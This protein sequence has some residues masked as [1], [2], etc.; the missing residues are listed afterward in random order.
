M[1]RDLDEA[2][3]HR[4][5]RRA[6]GEVRVG[7]AH[8]LGPAGGALQCVEERRVRAER[9]RPGVAREAAVQGRVVHEEAAL[10]LALRADPV[11]GGRDLR[12]TR[13]P[14]TRKRHA[15]KFG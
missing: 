5:L 10:L 12:P 2:P 4:D 3:V 9:L 6:R 15:L 7:L 1:L 13:E 14:S 11:P 8:G